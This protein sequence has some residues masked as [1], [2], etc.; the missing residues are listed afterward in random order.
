[1]NGQG[2]TGFPKA[3]AATSPSSHSERVG[4]RA[5][6]LDLCITHIFL[7]FFGDAV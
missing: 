3:K 5:S 2:Y 6:V 1:M 4:K 7:S